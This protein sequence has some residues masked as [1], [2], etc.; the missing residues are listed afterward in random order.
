MPGKSEQNTGDYIEYKPKHVHVNEVEPKKESNALNDY[1]CNIG[2]SP[3]GTYR[4]AQTW[5]GFIH[6]ML[7]SI[8]IKDVENSYL[9]RSYQSRVKIGRFSQWRSA[10]KGMKIS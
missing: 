10:K 4:K 3:P 8:H 6:N 5:T 1:R 7:I 9:W 2:S